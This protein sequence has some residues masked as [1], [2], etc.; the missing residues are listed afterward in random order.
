VG[1]VIAS[2]LLADGYQVDDL[3]QLWRMMDLRRSPLYDPGYGSP[4]EVVPRRLWIT[5]V[6]FVMMELRAAIQR[7]ALAI[8]VGATC[9]TAYIAL[10]SQHEFAGNCAYGRAAQPCCS[11]HA[12]GC[13]MNFLVQASQ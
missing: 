9:R 6:T 13:H 4:A 2:A 8:Q 10:T 1:K 7:Q 3:P 11:L 5:A 12:P